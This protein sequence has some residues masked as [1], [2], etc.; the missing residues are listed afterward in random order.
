MA[1]HRR[2]A[3]ALPANTSR[4]LEFNTRVGLDVKY[5]PS[6]IPG[7]KVPC[8]NLVDYA[9]ALQV[10]IPIGQKETGE[11]LQGAVRD[12][13]ISWAGPPATLAL[14]PAR[15]NLGEVFGEFCNNQGIAVDQTATEAHWQLGKV[16]RHGQWFQQ[17]FARVV[18][19]VR[20]ENEEQW[21][22]CIVQTQSAK[23]TLLTEAGAS[24]FQLVFGRNPR[25]P[26]D[27]LQEN[28]LPT[29]ADAIDL[30]SA[31][32]TANQIRQAARKAMLECQDSR[33]LRA[34]L[35]ARPRVLRE[36][37]SG[38]WVYYWR[39]QKSI[40]G[41]RQEG[42]RWYGAAMVL[43]NIGKNL[44]VA[45]K[46]SIMRCA[47]EQLR[48]ATPQER[49]VA[50][51]P[52]NELLGIKNLLERGQF[53]KSQFEDLVQHAFPPA[54]VENLDDSVPQPAAAQNAAQLQHLPSSPLVAA[55]QEPQS[56]TEASLPNSDPSV[57]Y[58]PQRRVLRKSAPPLYAKS[59]AR[60]SVTLHRPASEQPEDFLELMQD[61]VPQLL[62]S[63]PMS[64]ESSTADAASPRGQKRSASKDHVDAPDPAKLRTEGEG[65]ASQSSQLSH[66]EVA[67][68]SSP[69]NDEELR[70]FS[71]DEEALVT[72]VLYCEHLLNSKVEALMAAFMQKR[73]QKELPVQGNEPALQRDIDA[74]KVV[75][76]ETISGKQAVKVWTGRKAREIREHQKHRFVGSRFVVTNKIDEDGAR[77]KA[78]LCL[79]GHS[80]PD[81]DTKIRS[82]LCHSPTLSH[83]GRAVLLQ[84]MVSHHW[85]L[86]L[87]DVKGAFLEAGALKEQ[88]RP[89]YMTQPEGGIPG[90]SPEAVIE[91]TGNLYGANDAPYQW[92]TTF[93]EAAQQAGF[94]K[95]SFDNCLYFFYNSEGVLAGTLGAH[96]DDTITG[97]KG[98]AYEQAIAELKR[99]FPYRKWRVGGGEFCGILYTQN[100]HTF[101]VTY[102][103]AEYAR[104]L[105]PVA[106]SRERR[107]QPEALATEGEIKALRAINGAANWLSSQTRPDLSVQTSFSQQAFPNVRVKDLLFANQL[108]HR[109]RQHAR[110]SITVKDIP[111]QNLAI[112]F[113]SDA[114]FA[115]A[116]A[117]QTQAGYV[118]AFVDR[119][120]QED[121]ES[122]WSPFAWRSYK[123]PRVVASTLA[124]ET[125]AFSIA[126]GTAEWVSLMV[127]EAVQGGIDLRNPV[128]PRVPIVGMT[129]CKSLFDAVNS[130]SSP[131]KVEDKRVSIDLTIIRQ[132]M[133]RTHMKVRWVPTELM[134]ADSLTKDAADPADL[135]R[136][137]LQHGTYHLSPEATV[138]QQKKLQREERAFRRQAAE[139]FERS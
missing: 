62:Q 118:L 23:N 104:N 28:P 123:M 21:R 70:L 113:H 45:H 16:E 85:V 51:F 93:D 7:K 54:P 37:R 43:G 3:A 5:L 87:G 24:P 129:D 139:S 41:V 79:Q 9:T 12:R 34:A 68:P 138:L 52:Q 90:I 75:E 91:V 94:R 122:P 17:I 128:G 46:R 95:S 22:T 25:V 50:E 42:G 60:P 72:E 56:T 133:Q 67:A 63:F 10:L 108:V 127:L 114:G 40:A 32:Q 19:E 125:Q 1:N 126:S 83:L 15:P 131:A 77:V 117:N 111:L 18:D 120:L 66:P 136:A 11:L 48:P 132:A 14:D 64:S 6:W 61:V 92:Y 36:Y 96:V 103:Q 65:E 27:L 134:V 137:A 86:S 105:R 84:L 55:G 121:Q 33:A 109:A 26:S 78:R 47:P 58:G 81:F 110:V 29:V 102:Q 38:D 39:T 44:V 112:A 124:G 76:W 80:D 57:S 82:G 59:A 101:E 106:L 116:K 74:A 119:G 8:V 20:P 98:E 49:K 13:W 135:L 99:R 89:L 69:A 4:T 2:P 100:P 31:E 97:G 115:N 73:M 107:A 35:R 88:F 130:V 30:D 53:P 71:S